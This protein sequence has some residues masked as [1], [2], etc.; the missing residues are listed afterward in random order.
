MVAHSDG[1]AYAAWTGCVEEA[2]PTD[3]KCTAST[4]WIPSCNRPC[5]YPHVHLPPPLPLLS[6]QVMRLPDSELSGVP[7]C[8][9][10]AASGAVGLIASLPRDL[11]ELLAALQNGLK[12]VRRR[13]CLSVQASWGLGQ[14]L[15]RPGSEINSVSGVRGERCAE[16]ACN[17]NLWYTGA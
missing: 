5:S 2:T 1:R 7:T 12:K 6:A 17:S 3:T 9:Y 16:C 10:G 4:R 15:G 8:L 11:F 13:D 14:L